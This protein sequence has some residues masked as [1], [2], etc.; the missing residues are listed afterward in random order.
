MPDDKP[1]VNRVANSGLHTLKLEN[2][3]PDTDLVELDL[4]P[5]LF[6]GMILREKDFRQA[7]QEYDWPG[8]EG[9]DLTVY[10]SADA[11]IP[12]W[13]YMLVAAQAAPFANRVVQGNKDEY[14]RQVFQEKLDG[15][16]ASAY[17]GER[18]ILKGCSDKPVP[19]SA[20][21]ELT[22][23]LRP[24]AKSI[25]YGEPCSTVPIYKAPR[26]AARST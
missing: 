12:M 16:D 4:K 5:F 24:Y 22:R 23:K 19:A 6:Q 7:M 14:L 15:F 11:I 21:T 1:L 25:M 13:A 2:F 26:K 20:Y 8:L 10:C 18:V 9:K 17:E 3:H